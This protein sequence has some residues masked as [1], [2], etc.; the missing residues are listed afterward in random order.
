MGEQKVA[1]IW[2]CWLLE[3]A[4]KK[5]GHEI[6]IL[7]SPGTRKHKGSQFHI[8]WRWLRNL[9]FSICF[10]CDMEI[11]Q[12]DIKTDKVILEYKS[13]W[14][15][16]TILPLTN[17]LNLVTASFLF[18]TSAEE[19][20]SL[21]HRRTV[22]FSRTWP[23]CVTSPS[24]CKFNSLTCKAKISKYIFRINQTWHNFKV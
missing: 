12:K 2:I 10:H 21:Q 3:F 19:I 23:N 1:W 5:S 17:P 16:H 13:H 14:F 24:L 22:T 8:S 9:S 7:N 18:S 11:N 15:K 6:T 20:S 4:R